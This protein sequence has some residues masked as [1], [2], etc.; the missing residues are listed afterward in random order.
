MLFK[1]YRRPDPACHP[2]LRGIPRHAPSV[3]LLRM[4]LR[5]AERGRDRIPSMHY[6]QFDLRQRVS[7][8]GRSRSHVVVVLCHERYV[9]N[10]RQDLCAYTSHRARLLTHTPQYVVRLERHYT[11]SPVRVATSIAA[12]TSCGVSACLRSP[13]SPGRDRS[14]IVAVIR[15]ARAIDVT[16]DGTREGGRMG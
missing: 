7:P 6:V 5:K 4:T 13:R 16:H 9:F 8:G 2:P 12:S 10:V 11:D 3:L 15:I 1:D 14:R